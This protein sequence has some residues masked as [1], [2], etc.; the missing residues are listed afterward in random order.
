MAM[1]K[2]QQGSASPKT[3]SR[4]GFALL[5][6]VIFMSVMLAL[7][8]TLSS[9]GYKQ[10]VLASSAL[11]S[12]NAFYAADSGL[13]CGL[14]FD[15]RLN[16][17]AY[18]SDPNTPAPLMYCG[19]VGSLPV[20]SE[21]LLH[22]AE[23]WVVVTRIAYASGIYAR[24][25]DVTVYK[26]AT[27]PGT[28]YIF[29]QGYNVNCSVVAD[30]Q[31]ARIVS[32]GLATHYTSSAPITGS[33]G[34]GGA[35]TESGGNCIHTFTSSGTFTPPSATNVDYLVV[36][37]GGGGGWSRG[38]GGGAGGMT[39]GTLAIFGDTSVV[40]GSGGLGAVGFGKG[41][42]GGDSSFGS[43]VATGGGGGGAS[44]NVNGVSG[45]SGGGGA[46]DGAVGS[47]G[48]TGTA[49]QGN[50]GGSNPAGVPLAAA[51]GGGA[52]AVGS[53]GVGS[54]AGNGGAGAASSISGS[55][56]TYAGG[57]GGGNEA[58]G[59]AGIGGSGGGANGSASTAV[60]TPAGANT[61]GGGGGGGRTVSPS[62]EGN[63]GNGG[64]G[65]VI[66]RYPKP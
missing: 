55:S 12:Q 5:V 23:K 31:G 29:S 46:A 61:G 16:Y 65:I 9:L 49:G 6:A 62:V 4:G 27:N 15:Q 28:T 35:I 19:L 22:D 43:I 47:T 37:G 57:G 32:R 42:T 8:L 14:H 58:G 3:S 1:K 11:E 21:V 54:V 64:S 45:G 24:C 60:P 25:A 50:N 56:I 41:A 59:T 51:G 7:G 18:P 38:G 53:V 20:S 52:G 36:A 2:T 10:Q 34:S 44:N 33:C 13:E 39:A 63:G 48:G 30:P 17:F 40:V 26:P 66:I